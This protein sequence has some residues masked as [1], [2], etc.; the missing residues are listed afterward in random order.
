MMMSNSCSRSLVLIPFAVMR[1]IG[2]SLMSTS[3]TLGW[4]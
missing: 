3:S 1:S 2:D 4:L